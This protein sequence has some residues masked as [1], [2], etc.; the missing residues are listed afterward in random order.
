MAPFKYKFMATAR[1]VS[2]TLGFIALLIIVI[3]GYVENDFDTLRVIASILVAL[4]IIY[5]FIA[6]QQQPDEFKPNGDSQEA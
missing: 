2:I 3:Q 1:V 5:M 4:N 6:K